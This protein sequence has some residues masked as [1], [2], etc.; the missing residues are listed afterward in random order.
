MFLS[1]LLRRGGRCCDEHG[2][3]ERPV[4]DIED[5]ADMR[6]SPSD[7]YWYVLRVHI[8]GQI[9]HYL[10][11]GHQAAKD[12]MVRCKRLRAVSLGIFEDGFDIYTRPFLR[13]LTV[14]RR[15]LKVLYAIVTATQR[16]PVAPAANNDRTLSDKVKRSIV[17]EIS[18]S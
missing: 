11:H 7:R 6:I 15:M 13:N 5:V 8:W 3:Y 17:A 9:C 16:R 1:D 10:F 14:R 12:R 4:V 2:S 18:P